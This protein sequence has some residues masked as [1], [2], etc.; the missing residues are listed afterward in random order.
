MNDL[1]T[2]SYQS[3]PIEF[4][5]NGDVMINA[6]HMAKAFG[7]H[8]P[9]YLENEST[10]SFI[11]AL[12]Q[13]RNSDFEKE[14]SPH[15]KLVKVGRG[16]RN[17]GTWMHRHVALDFAMWLSPEFRVWVIQQI[18]E[19][20]FERKRQK[21]TY[22]HKRADLYADYKKHDALR[23]KYKE[24]LEL[25]EVY[26]KYIFHKEQ[27]AAVKAKLDGQDMEQFGVQ[28]DIEQGT[29]NKDNH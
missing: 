8:V 3:H 1:V 16:G 10:K 6:N 24:E 13:S 7:K 12:S 26:Q 23:A 14:F 20:L 15:G 11:K 21:E 29:H 25:S 28:L 4:S 27:K 22:F 5:V 17:P 2:I 9:H 18:D 19:I